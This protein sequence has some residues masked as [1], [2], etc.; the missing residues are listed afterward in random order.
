M[1][2]LPSIR[3]QG[4]DTSADD[5]PIHFHKYVRCKFFEAHHQEMLAAET[6]N[7]ATFDEDWRSKE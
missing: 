4:L 6:R 1:N 3:S 5:A 2:G 7:L